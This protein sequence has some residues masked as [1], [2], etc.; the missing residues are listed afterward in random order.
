MAADPAEDSAHATAEDAAEAPSRITPEEAFLRGDKARR[1]APPAGA[2]PDASADSAMGE[3]Q[4]PSALG[5]D[6]PAAEEPSG[7]AWAGEPIR[8]QQLAEIRAM[9][10][11]VQSGGQKS[12]ETGRGDE[13]ADTPSAP[14]APTPATATAAATSADEGRSS[15]SPAGSKWSA[16]PE[17][18]VPTEIQNKSEGRPAQQEA[19]VDDAGR[20]SRPT[21]S[22]GAA[23]EMGDDQEFVTPPGFLRTGLLVILLIGALMTALYVLQPQITS[24]IPSTAPALDKYI[25]MIDRLRA[26]IASDYEWVKGKVAGERSPAAEAGPMDE[27]AATGPSESTSNDR[28][29]SGGE[30]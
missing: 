3:N 16:P 23:H 20:S 4:P 26:H 24:R 30:R 28:P 11:E 7:K 10:A 13:E 29:S 6:A 9:L 18:E 25:E 12:R 5:E 8:Q 19:A 14:E 1:T 22:T 15:F 2:E 21:A 17:K 27:S